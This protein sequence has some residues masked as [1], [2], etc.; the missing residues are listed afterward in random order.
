MTAIIKVS[1]MDLTIVGTTT[2][3]EDTWPINWI[4]YGAKG[5][6]IAVICYSQKNVSW[7]KLCIFLSYIFKRIHERYCD[8]LQNDHF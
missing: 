3:K 8:F 7:K 6:D 1:N 2:K 4:G 5:L